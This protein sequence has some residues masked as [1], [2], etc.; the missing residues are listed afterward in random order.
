MLVEA[1]KKLESTAPRQAEVAWLR[2]VAG[3]TINQVAATLDIAPRTVNN[4]WQY[5]QAWLRRELSDDKR[6]N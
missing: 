4:D 1:L 3:L 6:E 2:Y 5:A